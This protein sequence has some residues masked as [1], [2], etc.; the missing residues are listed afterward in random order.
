M[1]LHQLNGWKFVSTQNKRSK[2]NNSDRQNLIFT[3]WTETRG[4]SSFRMQSFSPKYC[5]VFWLSLVRWTSGRGWLVVLGRPMLR[6]HLVGAEAISEVL[7]SHIRRRR[8]PRA[9]RG[10]WNRGVRRWRCRS[11]RNGGR[12]CCGRC[13]A[14]QECS[15]GKLLRPRLALPEAS[16]V[17]L[18]RPLVHLGQQEIVVRWSTPDL[19]MLAGFFQQGCV[20]AVHL[21]TRSGGELGHQGIV[22]QAQGGTQVLLQEE[23]FHGV[24]G[25]EGERKVVLGK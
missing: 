3:Q 19:Q 21:L 11:L 17:H 18:G 24:S 10:R 14:L 12:C 23:G 16:Q 6:W 13:S 25:W 20:G 15:R 8:R 22:E 9:G 4:L 7:G 2:I 5:M 1:W